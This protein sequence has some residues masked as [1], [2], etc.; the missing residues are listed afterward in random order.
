MY[1]FR[2]NLESKNTEVGTC[3]SGKNDL[4]IVRLFTK[5]KEN[6]STQRCV[7]YKSQWLGLRCVY[8]RT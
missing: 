3:V 7:A 5:T 8:V 6:P 2:I 1:R 4:Q